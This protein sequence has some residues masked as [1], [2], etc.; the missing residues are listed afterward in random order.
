M[1]TVAIAAI[2]AVSMTA[3]PAAHADPNVNDLICQEM[4]M[5]FS[6]DQTADSLHSGDP[7]MPA[8]IARSSYVLSTAFQ[9]VRP[10]LPKAVDGRLT[11]IKDSV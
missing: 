8:Y 2:L 10:W 6:D 9:R 7:T 11:V 3:A 1:K 5:G 4:R